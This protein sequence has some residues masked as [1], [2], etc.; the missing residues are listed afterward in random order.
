MGEFPRDLQLKPFHVQSRAAVDQ[1]LI[2]PSKLRGVLVHLVGVFGTRL[3]SR[4]YCFAFPL[5][6]AQEAICVLS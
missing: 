1:Q 3:Q 5:L 6:V 2:L 4:D